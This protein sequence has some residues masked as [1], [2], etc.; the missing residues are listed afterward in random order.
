VNDIYL[1]LNS[2]QILQD[3]SSQ[4]VK[5]VTVIYSGSVDC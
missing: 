3:V 1:Y 2:I 5:I 4:T